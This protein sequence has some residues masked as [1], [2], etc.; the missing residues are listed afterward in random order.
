MTTIPSLCGYLVTYIYACIL[1]ELCASFV[2]YHILMRLDADW[3]IH[4]IRAWVIGSELS[5]DC[6]DINQA[7]LK[8]K[9]NRSQDSLDV[10]K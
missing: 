8:I 2:L 1:H 3:F 5:Y 7:T 10:I 9:I 4:T 6:L